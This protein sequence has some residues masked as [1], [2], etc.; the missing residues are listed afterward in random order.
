MLVRTFLATMGLVLLVGC[1]TPA[2][3]PEPRFHRVGAPAPVE[4]TGAAMPGIVVVEPPRAAGVLSDRAIAYSDQTNGLTLRQYPYHSWITSP[5][6]LIQQQFI[7]AL[8]DA[9]AAEFVL[10][11]SAAPDVIAISGDL[12]RFQRQRRGNEWYADVA[13]RLRV[14]RS[15]VTSPVLSN[16]YEAS[17]PAQGVGMDET[18]LAF[19]RALDAIIADFVRDL[20]SR[21]GER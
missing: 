10:K 18:A 15:G 11:T 2:P 6:R 13:I 4:W 3:I 20:A 7:Q 5:S 8:A 12:E 21:S 9:N 16:R 1:G 14:D 19:T 17:A